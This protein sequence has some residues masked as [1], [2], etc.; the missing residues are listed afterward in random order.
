MGL[1]RSFPFFS[2][3]RVSYYALRFMTLSDSCT[4]VMSAPVYVTFLAC[5]FLKEPCGVFHIISIFVT[6][7]GVVLITRP[8]FLFGAPLEGEF[9]TPDQNLIGALLSLISCLAVSMTF[10]WIR[11]LQ[12]TT[13]SVVIIWFSTFC[14]VMGLIVMAILHFLFQM[15]LG[16]PVTLSDYGYCT[17]NAFC[18]VSAQFFLVYSLKLEEAGLVSLVRAFDIVVSFLFQFAILKEQTIVWT[19]ILGAVI[20][21]M[22]VAMSCVKKLYESRPDYFP[23]FCLTTSKAEHLQLSVTV[24]VSPTDVGFTINSKP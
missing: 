19:S 18:G 4:I 2:C 12:K 6:M 23:E 22:G 24:K 20:V 15:E 13:T 5:V 10:V 11:K 14:I 1:I 3:C 8:A 17:A 9:F 16:L 21:T 7:S